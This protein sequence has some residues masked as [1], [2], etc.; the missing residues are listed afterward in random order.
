MGKGAAS[1][2]ISDEGNDKITDDVWLTRGF[3]GSLFNART[4]FGHSMSVSPEGTEWAIGNTDNLEN[5]VFDVFRRTF[6]RARDTITEVDV[7]LHLIEDDIFIDMN[8]TVWTTG[9]SEVGPGISYSRTTAPIVGVQSSRAKEVQV[10]Y[11]NPSTDGVFTFR[12]DFADQQSEI[13]IT[14]MLGRVVFKKSISSSESNE[15]RIDLSELPSNIYIFEQVTS[16]G[17]YTQSIT[18]E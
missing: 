16:S 5:L 4:E 8:F 12:N 9:R 7:V 2:R 1:I 10:I 14:N 17:R 13:M 6:I 3:I 15:I 11:P 18:I